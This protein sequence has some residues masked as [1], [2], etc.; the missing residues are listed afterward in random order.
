MQLSSK[1][2]FGFALSAMLFALCASTNAQQPRK[3]L[4]GYLDYGA[5]D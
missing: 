2:V 3:M 5:A 4:I 1:S